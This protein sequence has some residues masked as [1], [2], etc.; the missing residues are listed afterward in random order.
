MARK[1]AKNSTVFSHPRK[2][3]S[4]FASR[5]KFL[6]SQITKT[7]F[8]RPSATTDDGDQTRASEEPSSA[9]SQPPFHL[10]EGERERGESAW[11]VIYLSERCVRRS[12]LAPALLP[13][14]GHHRASASGATLPMRTYAPAPAGPGPARLTNQ[15][16]YLKRS[17]YLGRFDKQNST[18]LV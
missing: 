9:T 3:L 5:H 6:R 16:E 4:W 13:W 8:R 18:K 1:H 12:V 15:I 10:F 17:E 11:S 7:P 2:P 14:L